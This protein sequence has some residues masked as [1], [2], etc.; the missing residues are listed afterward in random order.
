MLRS[1]VKIKMSLETLEPP[2]IDN[3]RLR[4]DEL[5]ALGDTA[6]ESI[7][8][9]ITNDG[10]KLEA[11][12]AELKFYIEAMAAQRILY[13]VDDV[14]RQ[15][16]GH[17]L[18]PMADYK[19]PNKLTPPEEVRSG[20][21]LMRQNHD[22]L[23]RYP[24][25][26]DSVEPDCTVCIPVA[27]NGEDIEQVAKAVEL[28][29]ESQRGNQGLTEIVVWANAKLD[30]HS[31]EDQK[32]LAEKNYALLRN[33]LK[34]LEGEGICIRTALQ[35]LDGESAHM[36]QVRSNYM[37]A[38]MIEA[39][40]RG[41]AL[42]HPIIWL[43]A[44]T[45][46]ISKGAIKDLADSVK[47]SGRP[48][49]HANLRFTADWAAN[50][51]I[52]NLDNPTKAVAINE[53]HRR[54]LSRDRINQD[55]I[56]EAGLAFLLGTYARADGVE[57]WD[58]LNESANLISKVQ[59]NQREQ[60]QD[61]V[62]TY[63]RAARIGVSARRQYELAKQKG[64]GGLVGANSLG[65]KDTYSSMQRFGDTVASITNA[66]VMDAFSREEELAQGRQYDQEAHEALAK[67][68][69]RRKRQIEH[70]ANRSF[71]Q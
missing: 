60:T 71:S 20:L 18:R 35:V 52:E 28:I 38:V 66:D 27:I 57:T 45:T 36:S 25:S 12:K 68:A 51:Q 56:E 9:V 41:W 37:D 69:N 55:Y 23:E 59:L 34:T 47:T 5:E 63:H 32:V 70:L 14:R 30:A 24:D 53:I 21:G 33:R 43:D 2:T 39:Y 49:V 46:E 67:N 19:E 1:K 17:V 11:S 44:D 16:W 48:F 6:L 3:E 26:K 42:D 50:S 7:P 58:P 15:T 62:V 8:V 4:K 54:K 31:Q 22:L 40:D 29:K 64:A 13:P 65:Y 10:E 61:G